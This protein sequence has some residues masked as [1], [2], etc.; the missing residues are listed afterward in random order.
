MYQIKEKHSVEHVPFFDKC[1]SDI[2]MYSSWS[3]VASCQ[4]RINN[5]K[6]LCHEKY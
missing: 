3:C 4:F 5:G 2:F 1:N 6:R